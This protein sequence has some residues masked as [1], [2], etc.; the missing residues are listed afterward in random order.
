MSYFEQ[1]YDSLHESE[2]D[3]R[4]ALEE[5]LQERDTILNDE[6][7]NHYRELPYSEDSDYE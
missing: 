5:L 3:M 1:D 4:R 7:V 6:T 2:D